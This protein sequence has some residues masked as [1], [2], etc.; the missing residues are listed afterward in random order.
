MFIGLSNVFP[1]SLLFANDTSQFPVVLSHHTTYS[2]LLL[3][4][5]AATIVSTDV[6]LDGGAF[7][8]F[9]GELPIPFII[10]E[11]PNVFPLSLLALENTCQFP[12]LLSHHVT[13]TLLPEAAIWLS[14]E[15][16][17]S[18]LK[19][20]GLSKLLPASLLPEKY[21]SLFPVLLSHHV[22]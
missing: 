5:A 6:V 2:L 15:P 3:P 10:T 18:L 16:P 21:T 20:I 9:T 4:A 11:S 7:R 13:Y 22:R 17:L 19:L 14:A 12:V 8:C 1:P